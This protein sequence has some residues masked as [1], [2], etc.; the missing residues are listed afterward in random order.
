LRWEFNSGARR[1]KKL[2]VL[3]SCIDLQWR[4]LLFTRYA[5]FISFLNPS[6]QGFVKIP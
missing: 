5:E 3:H 6:P 2:P 4:Y 1:L